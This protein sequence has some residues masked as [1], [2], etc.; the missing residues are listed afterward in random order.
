MG[1]VYF[2]EPPQDFHAVFEAW[3]DNQWVVFDPTKMAPI[4]RLVRVGTGRDA[5]DVAFATIF[6]N[7]QMQRKELQ[8]IESDRASAQALVMA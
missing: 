2:Q 7:V 4:D 1:Y 8:V 5:K 3:L 6:G